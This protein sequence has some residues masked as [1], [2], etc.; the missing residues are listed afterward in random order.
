[1]SREWYVIIDG[2]QMGPLFSDKVQGLINKGALKPDDMVWCQEMANWQ[3]LKDLAKFAERQKRITNH[4]HQASNKFQAPK[5]K[6]QTHNQAPQE[7]FAPPTKAIA[8][9]TAS[10]FVLGLTLSTYWFSSRVEGLNSDLYESKTAIAEYKGRLDKVS[11][12]A[13]ETNALF[14]HLKALIA[15]SNEQFKNANGDMIAEIDK[16]NI[17]TSSNNAEKFAAKGDVKDIKSAVSN[18]E[19]EQKILSEKFRDVESALDTLAERFLDMKATLSESAK[20]PP[21]QPVAAQMQE[22]RPAEEYFANGNKKY[23]S[24][25]YKGAIDDYSKAIYINPSYATAFDKLGGCTEVSSNLDKAAKPN[26][27]AKS[28]ADEPTEDTEKNQKTE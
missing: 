25:D 16:L 4:K 6:L 28:K 3:T 21:K 24:G 20:T 9:A 17:V 11:L 5:T 14:N 13:D 15:E 2:R 19:S 18:L 7:L 27:I 26:Q 12:R 1:M 10:V 23:T 22:N 8:F